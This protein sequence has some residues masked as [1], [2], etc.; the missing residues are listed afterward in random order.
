MF[1][2]SAELSAL[3]QENESN[4]ALLQ[5]DRDLFAEYDALVDESGSQL[6]AR[7]HALRALAQALQRAQAERQSLEAELQ[8][9]Q[10]RVGR[11][12]P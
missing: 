2:D 11:G 1:A 9:C 3:R 4:R 6:S 8:S 5:L 7:E 10:R 12:I